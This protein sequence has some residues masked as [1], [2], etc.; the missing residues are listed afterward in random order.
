MIESDVSEELQDV[1]D[2]FDD[3]ENDGDVEKNVGVTILNLEEKI[4]SPEHVFPLNIYDP[5]V[6]DL[7]NV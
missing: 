3:H 2:E 7:L 4:K 6:W 5:R 1:G